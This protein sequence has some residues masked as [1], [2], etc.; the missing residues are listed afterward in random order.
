MF[1]FGTYFVV[2]MRNRS[3]YFSANSALV[4]LKPALMFECLFCVPIKS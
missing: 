1:L 3:E 2:Y 4:F